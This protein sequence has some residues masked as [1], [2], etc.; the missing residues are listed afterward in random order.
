VGVRRLGVLCGYTRGDRLERPPRGF[1]PEHPLIEA[2]KWK[3]Y[4]GVRPVREAFVTGSA[5]PDQLVSLFRVGTPYHALL[6]QGGGR[7]VLTGPLHQIACVWRIA[8]LSWRDPRCPER[9]QEAQVSSSPK[10]LAA[11][12]LALSITVSLIAAPVAAQSSSPVG[13]WDVVE[14]VNWSPEG[15]RR[16][17][18][19]SDPNAMFVYTPGGNLILHAT[20]DPLLAPQATP[21]STEDLAHRASSTVAY[22]GTYTVDLEKSEIV[23]HIQGDL[24]PNRAGRSVARAFRI[25]D[26]ELILDW[27]NQD[28]SRFYRRLRRLEAF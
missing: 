15:E 10:D 23:H 6:M 19:G 13:V 3:D 22:Y 28:G 17:A 8:P 18:L 16:E 4:I 12:G 20:T 14:W 5:L 9:S 11:T 7:F 1:D 25:E 26:G 27:M 2:L 24:L 21:P